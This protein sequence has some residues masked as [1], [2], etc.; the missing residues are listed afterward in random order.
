MVIPN[1]FDCDSGVLR[2]RS[3]VWLPR[4]SQVKGKVWLLW[5]S[6]DLPLLIAFHEYL[7]SY[8][9]MATILK[10]SYALWR[11]TSIYCTSSP[12]QNA[13]HRRPQT[14]IV[15]L[16]LIDVAVIPSSHSL[17]RYRGSSIALLWL[18]LEVV[19]LSIIITRILQCSYILLGR[20]GRDDG[21]N[22]LNFC[23]FGWSFSSHR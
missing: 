20:N 16:I 7:Y 2:R 22:D 8:S 18:E 4:G 6:A 3:S 10:W 14:L 13:F 9:H 19:L 23:C 5:W 12:Q 1:S 21:A 15:S 17:S 11:S